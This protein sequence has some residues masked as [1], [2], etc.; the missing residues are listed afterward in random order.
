MQKKGDSIFNN[1]GFN[2]WVRN[3]DVNDPK[4]LA[5]VDKRS[6]TSEAYISDL[7][8]A[9]RIAERKSDAQRWIPVRGKRE[10]A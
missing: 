7:E 3:F 6:K 4:F 1:P 5:Q 2:E 8:K 9:Q 10:R